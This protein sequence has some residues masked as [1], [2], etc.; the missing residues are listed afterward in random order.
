METRATENTTSQKKMMSKKPPLTRRT[1]SLLDVVINDYSPPPQPKPEI[2]HINIQSFEPINNKMPLKAKPLSSLDFSEAETNSKRFGLFRTE[3]GSTIQKTR[4]GQDIQ[5]SAHSVLP[6]KKKNKENSATYFNKMNGAIPL[7]SELEAVNCFFYQFLIPGMVP[8][9]HP[10]YDDSKPGMPF[11]SIYSKKL[12]DFEPTINSPLKAEDLESKKVVIGLAY[13]LMASFIFEEDDLH[14]GNMEKDGRRIDFDMSLW[15][16]ISK[17]KV[18]SQGDYW[19]RLPKEDAFMV[20]AENIKCFPNVVD[21]Q[22]PFYHPTQPQPILPQP[23]YTQVAMLFGLSKNSFSDEDNKL[24]SQLENDPEFK[25]ATYKVLLKFILTD[26]DFYI[27]CAKLFVRESEESEKM[28]NTLHVHLKN[29]ISLFRSVLVKMPEF[30]SFMQLNGMPA[31]QEILK[32]I[33]EWNAKAKNKIQSRKDYR[34][35]LINLDTLKDRYAKIL[36]ETKKNTEVN[37]FRM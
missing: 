30:Q 2:P 5:K 29:R 16:I 33:G 21:G 18:L 23:L 32:E 19:F 12:E 20:T 22:K 36:K 17:Y 24:Y 7:M 26:P 37:H 9:A 31:M 27:H 35:I 6:V 34:G 8:T 14:R 11:V 28:L 10:V 1:G 13:C 4:S 3:S 25:K 15:P